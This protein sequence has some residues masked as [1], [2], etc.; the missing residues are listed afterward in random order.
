M[1]AED[2]LRDCQAAVV[3]AT[4]DLAAKRETRDDAIRS[5]IRDGMSMYRVAQ[6]IGIR[7]QTVAQIRDA[8][9]RRTTE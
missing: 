7:Q 8:D 5:A 3:Q 9:G 1:S 6:I 4:D 2:T